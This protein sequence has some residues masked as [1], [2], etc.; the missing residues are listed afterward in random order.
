MADAHSL[1]LSIRSLQ[2]TKLV[3]YL[4]VSDPVAL[5]TD[6]SMVAKFQEA[7]KLDTT[8][9]LSKIKLVVLDE[10]QGDALQVCDSVF[11]SHVMGT[12]NHLY[13]SGR[14]ILMDMELPQFLISRRETTDWFPA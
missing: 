12:D 8:G 9:R 6:R 10:G 3:H 7:K 13:N 4:H 2:P 11:C 5:F 14:V 1:A